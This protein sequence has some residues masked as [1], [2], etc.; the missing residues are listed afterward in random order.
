[1]MFRFAEQRRLLLQAEFLRI[2]GE[3]PALGAIRFWPAGDLAEQR[4]GP[5]SELEILII[6]DTGQPFRRRSDFFTTHLRPSVGTRFLVYT[7]DEADAL[8]ESDLLLRRTI[9]LSDA[10]QA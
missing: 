1:M 7:P 4:V 2:A 10:V 8:E 6:H 9:R 5:G 3:L